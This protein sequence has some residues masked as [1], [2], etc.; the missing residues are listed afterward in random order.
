MPSPWKIRL[1]Q[2]FTWWSGETMGTK[3]YTRRFGQFVGEDEFG[4]RYY[5]KPGIAPNLHFERRWPAG[6]AGCTTSLTC[7]QRRKPTCRASGR[8]RTCPT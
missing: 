3:L 6:T 1:L 2:I 5:R 7:H 8:S 4:N